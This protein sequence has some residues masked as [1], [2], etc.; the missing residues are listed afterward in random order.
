[1]FAHLESQKGYSNTN[2]N[3]FLN[4]YVNHLN[5]KGQQGLQ[6]ILVQEQIQM[7]GIEVVYLVREYQKLDTFWGEDPENNFS[8]AKKF[9]AYLEQFS[10]YEGQNEIFQKFGMQINDEITIQINPNL[11]HQQTGFFPKEGD[12]LYFPLDKALFEITW[13]TPREQF[14]QNGILSIT[15]IQAQKFIY[16]YEKLDPSITNKE[17]SSDLYDLNTDELTQLEQEDLEQLFSL[18]EKLK[19]SKDVYEDQL[20]EDNNIHKEFAIRNID[21]TPTNGNSPFDIEFLDD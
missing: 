20:K 3:Y 7:N 5:H 10:G 6:D 11:F 14:Y 8:N 13:C 19:N 4:P 18:S 12:L 21:T 2:K 16:S 9:Q 1:M 15:K 17:I